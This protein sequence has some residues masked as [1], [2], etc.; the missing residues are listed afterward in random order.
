MNEP[1]AADITQRGVEYL[2]ELFETP[3]STGSLT[4]GRAEEGVGVPAE[5]SASVS[6]LAVALVDAVAPSV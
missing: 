5:V 2:R 3:E 4:A 1:V 6:V